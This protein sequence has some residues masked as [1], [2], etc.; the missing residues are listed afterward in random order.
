MAGN[1]KVLKERVLRTFSAIARDYHFCY[2]CCEDITPGEEYD[3]EVK[4]FRV[5]LESGRL[6][7]YVIT[8]RRHSDP[9]E[10]PDEPVDDDR[11]DDEEGA[12]PFDQDS[13]NEDDDEQLPEA[14]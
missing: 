3:A 2:N 7:D 4:A 10:P 13:L 14:A 12:E 8:Y 9:C 11:F 6:W 5:R 1:R